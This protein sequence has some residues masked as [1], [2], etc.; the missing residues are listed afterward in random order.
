MKKRKNIVLVTLY[1]D[2]N[3]GNRLQNFALQYI[4]TNLGANVVTLNNKYTTL[5]DHKDILKIKIKSVLGK[6]GIQNYQN[7]Y[8]YFKANEMKRKAN[9]QFDKINI[10]DVLYI[11][12]EEAFEYDWSKFDFAIVGS[13][14]VWHKWRN[15]FY[16]LPFYY[17]EFMPSNKRFAYA[18]SF[19]LENLP[20]KDLDQ[21]KIGLSGMNSISCRENTGCKIVKNTIGIDVPRVL[22]PTLL[23][24]ESEWRRIAE[25]ASSFAKSQTKYAFIYFLG[26]VTDEYRLFM[27]KKLEKWGIV[28]IIDFSN[29][30]NLDISKCGPSGFLSLIDR[31]DYIFTDSFHCTVF[32][33]IF[34]KKFYVFRRSQIGFENMFSRI[35]DL[36]ASKGLVDRI[37][38]GTL[39]K[40]SNDFDEI[41][42]QSIEFLEKVITM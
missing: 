39:T 27:E 16:E 19:G 5:P 26:E 37:Y 9:E 23:L 33:V 34:N 41:Y 12:N 2:N 36:L 14:Q 1:D 20:L 31:A 17:L 10:K 35:E 15:D 24:N 21:H 40:D 38:G 42:R 13:D 8:N 32:S 30:T 28:N 3:I 6:L 25:Q 18:A 22:D 4:L 7:D 29:C 11:T